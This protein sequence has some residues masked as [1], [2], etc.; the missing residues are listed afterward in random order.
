MRLLAAILLALTAPAEGAEIAVGL[1][2][3]IV[4]VDAGFS[5]ARLVL[6]G[7]LAGADAA[8]L[9]RPSPLDIVAVVRG[10][11]TNF[12]IRP[13]ERRGFIWIRG[14]SA[15][16]EDAP[17]ILLTSATRPLGEIAAPALRR[18]L[19][20]DAASLDLG[21][22]LSASGEATRLLIGG[23]AGRV[24]DAFLE[25][26]RADGRYRE[27]AD[28][29]TFRKGALF[30]ID[31]LL[32]PTTPVGD[33]A[34]DVFLFRDGAVVSHDQASLVVSKVGLERRIYDFAHNRPVSYGLGCVFLAVAAGWLASL[35]FRK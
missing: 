25:A 11:A 12:R 10:P 34:V 30:S 28:A 13:V 6:F 23:G 3:E 31:V 20:L 27:T 15:R 22:R 1:T 9:L 17:A 8:D 16:L 24:V 2:D 29:V 19:A 14:A 5:G 26:G 35:A 33:Y 4:E 7:A 18:S 21:Q 32:P